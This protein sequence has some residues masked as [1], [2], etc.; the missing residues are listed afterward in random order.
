M[1]K[2]SEEEMIEEE[3]EEYDGLTCLQILPV[4]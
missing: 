1:K 3:D 4:L 2:V